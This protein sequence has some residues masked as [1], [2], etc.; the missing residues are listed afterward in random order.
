MADERRDVDSRDANGGGAGTITSEYANMHGAEKEDNVLFSES[1]PV[2]RAKY[3]FRDNRTVT[4]A[5]VQDKKEELQSFLAKPPK[6]RAMRVLNMW[7]PFTKWLPYYNLR[8]FARDILAG[9]TVGCML[10]PQGISY[11]GIAGLPPQ[12]GLYSGFTPPYIYALIGTSRQLVVGPV[13]LISLLVNDA[14]SGRVAPLSKE[15]VEI[16]VFL[17]MANGFLVLLVGLLKLGFLINFLG[18]AVVTGFISA[19]A[20]IIMAQQAG[21]ALGYK[22]PRSELIHKNLQYIFR[23]IKKTQGSTIGIF[24]FFLIMLLTFKFLGKRVRRLRFLPYIGPLVSIIAATLFIVITKLDHH[25][26]KVVGSIPKGAPPVSLKYWSL[27]HLDHGLWRHVLIIAILGHVESIVIGKKLA[28]QHRYELS[29]NHELVGLGAANMVGAIFSSY[30][31][32]GSFS[33]SAVNNAVGAKTQIAGVITATMIL[34]VIL[35]LTPLFKKTPQPVLAAIIVNAVIGLIDPLEWKFFWKVSKRDFLLALAT[36]L[37]TAFAGIEW[38]VGV[39]IGL[40]LLFVL[41]ESGHPHTAILGKLPESTIYRNIRQYP[42]AKTQDGI[43]VLRIDAP[44]YFANVHYLKEHIR[45]IEI[46]TA[47]SAGHVMHVDHNIFKDYLKS[48]TQ[49]TK[50]EEVVH[51]TDTVSDTPSPAIKF[52]ILDLTPVPTVDTSGIRAI[53][54]LNEEYKARGVQLVLVNPSR[55]VI[56]FLEKTGVLDL[57]GRD[58]LFVRVHD[59]VL[60][61]GTELKAFRSNAIASVDSIDV[62]VTDHQQHAD[63]QWS[64][65]IYD[66]ANNAKQS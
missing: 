48:N 31:V 42:E 34:F 62:R 33:R 32:T 39:G 57:I 23:D 20:F 22:L 44:I 35:F 3:G 10:I 27:S 8:I 36:F 30:P 28:T 46:E 63:S 9:L 53:S 59:A 60:R 65:A 2:Y 12:Y 19:T 61:C 50:S 25:G 51:R 15:A 26:V 24:L 40:S 29:H 41:Y 54:E 21:N 66:E 11:A 38:G 6:A 64:G 7:F 13:A 56:A 58:W 5:F 1:G 16:A 52:L 18:H 49:E 17:A 14:I 4:Q 47:K 55:T 43:L 45:R 37:L